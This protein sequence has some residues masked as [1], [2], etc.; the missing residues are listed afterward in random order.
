MN[1]LWDFMEDKKVINSKKNISK[2]PKLKSSR[3]F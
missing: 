2:S 1:K 3:I